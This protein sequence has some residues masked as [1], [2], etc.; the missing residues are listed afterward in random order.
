MWEFYIILPLLEIVHS[1]RSCT[2]HSDTHW[3]LPCR[4][5]KRFA[6]ESVV[7]AKPSHTQTV[8]SILE[9][10]LWEFT[11]SNRMRIGIYTILHY[12]IQQSSPILQNK[13][14]GE[15]LLWL[16]VS[17]T[18]C[19]SLSAVYCFKSGG[20]LD[21]CICRVCPRCYHCWE[22]VSSKADEIT[23]FWVMNNV[24][25]TSPTIW[26]CL[27]DSFWDLTRR[28]LF[29]KVKKEKTALRFKLE[30][31]LHSKYLCFRNRRYIVLYIIVLNS[32]GSAT[33]T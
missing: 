1:S 23:F 15:R 7:V 10:T 18:W 24:C 30:I 32:T 22:E 13:P 29:E 16:Y 19:H 2:Y 8:N 28:L 31:Y 20:Q 3:R 27:S 25:Q 11:I 6:Q 21:N 14:A 5:Q 33:P 17:N 4:I 26:L 9:E 12:F